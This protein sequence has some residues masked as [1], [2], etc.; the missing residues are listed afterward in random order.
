MQKYIITLNVE[1]EE[2]PFS[3]SALNPKQAEKKLYSMIQFAKP[4]RID[5]KEQYKLRMKPFE[6]KIKTNFVR[7]KSSKSFTGDK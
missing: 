3:V 2:V 5:T 4:I 1:G 6:D 7:T